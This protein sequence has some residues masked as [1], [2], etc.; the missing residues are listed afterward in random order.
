ME[1]Y[2]AVI[3]D[4]IDH[5]L[6]PLMHTAGYRAL[7]LEAKYLRFRVSRDQLKDAAIGLRSLGF[8]G[9]NVTIPHKEAIISY[10]DELTPAAVAAGAVNTVKNSEGRLIGHNTDGE[11]FIRAVSESVSSWQGKTAVILGA[12][13]AAR[14]IAQALNEKGMRLIIL[15]R[16]AGKAEELA[17]LLRQNGGEVCAGKLAAGPWLSEAD[18]VVQTTPVGLGGEPYPLSLQGIREGTLAVDIIYKPWQT[19]FLR[20]AENLGCRTMNGLAMFLHQGALAWEFWRGEQAPLPAMR[21]A[22][23][24]E[25][26]RVEPVAKGKPTRDNIALIGFM[27]TGKSSVGRRLALALNWEFIDTDEEIEKVSGLSVAEMFQRH[28]ETRFRSE[29]NLVLRRLGRMRHYVIAT[30]G[31]MVVN[32]ENRGL[33]AERALIISLYAPLDKILERVGDRAQ[34]PLL[35]GPRE[36]IEALWQARQSVYGQADLIVDTSELDVDGVVREIL[37][38]LSKMPAGAQE[39]GEMEP[40]GEEDR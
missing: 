1:S 35:R 25:K 3:G 14:G 32:E 26:A 21:A 5:S 28:G 30:G 11:G 18:L 27:A 12:G 36:K 39:P 23:A 10:L 38:E 7:G 8:A 13:G 4:P 9:W 37:R 19:P 17:R 33:L 6:S 29:E 16:T 15:N 24:E 22:L 40:G 31:G 20:E 34:R 2:Y